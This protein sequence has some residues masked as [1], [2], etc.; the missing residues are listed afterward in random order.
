MQDR[1][2]APELLEAIADFLQDEVSEHVPDWL[3][4]QL[5]VAR[6]SLLI[7]KREIE[8]EERHLHSEWR[9]LDELLGATEPPATFRELRTALRDRNEQLCTAIREGGFDDQSRRSHLLAHLH[10]TVREK[11]SITNPRYVTGT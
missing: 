10:A 11:L 7:V 8:S 5:R 2:T 3:S 4:F 1:P 6:N 9:R